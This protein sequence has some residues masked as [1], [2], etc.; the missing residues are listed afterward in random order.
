MGESGAFQRVTATGVV[1]RSLARV[2]SRT[3]WARVGPSV[4][5]PLLTLATTILFDVLARHG[6]P[7][8]HP[9]PFLLFT[10]V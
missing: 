1:A 10:A 6:F 2:T 4:R 5:G 3:E 9:F 8:A 7:I